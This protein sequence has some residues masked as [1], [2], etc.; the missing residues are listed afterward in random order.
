MVKK[1]SIGVVI[2]VLSSFFLS[3][4][5]QENIDNTDDTSN[6]PEFALSPTIEL[7][8]TV[9]SLVN[10]TTNKTSDQTYPCDYG[11]IKIDTILSINN[12]DNQEMDH[13]EEG[14]EIDVEYIY[15]SQKAEIIEFPVLNAHDVLNNTT[16]YSAPNL[17]VTKEDGLFVFMIE[18][19][20]LDDETVTILPGLKN[21]TR[22][23]ANVTYGVPSKIRQNGTHM[24]LTSAIG[25]YEVI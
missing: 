8:A 6:T 13:I 10:G 17:I 18:N 9:I 25:K 4:C 16:V 2:V 14:M 7:E 24:I 1:V 19:S 11:I 21:G 23:Y 20:L 22:I 5:I 3:G 15:T 12:P